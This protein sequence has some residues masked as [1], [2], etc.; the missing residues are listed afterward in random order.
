MGKGSWQRRNL[1]TLGILK[2][3]EL[4]VKDSWNFQTGSIMMDSSN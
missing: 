2:K 4:K 3:V 1:L